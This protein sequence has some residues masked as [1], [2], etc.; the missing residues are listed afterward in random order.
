MVGDRE[1]ALGLVGEGI[2]E[3][4]DLEILLLE[5]QFPR[6]VRSSPSNLQF[7]ISNLQSPQG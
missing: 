3:K 5:F 7:S 6:Q 1:P 2:K 4:G